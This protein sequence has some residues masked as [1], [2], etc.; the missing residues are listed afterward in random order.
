MTEPGFMSL[1]IAPV[2][3]TGAGRPGMSAV[4][5]AMSWV[6]STSWTRSVWRRR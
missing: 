6:L 2:I 4:Q 3:K 1:T 5:M